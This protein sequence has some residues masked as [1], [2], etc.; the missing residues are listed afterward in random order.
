[1]QHIYRGGIDLNKDF[2]H[3]V[4]FDPGGAIPFGDTALGVAGLDVGVTR[5]VN[6]DLNALAGYPYG[7]GGVGCV[8]T[9]GL[10]YDLGVTVDAVNGGAFDGSAGAFPWMIRP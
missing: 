8:T 6:Y 7:D 1:M 3:T 10:G 2:S 4:N 9:G 5:G